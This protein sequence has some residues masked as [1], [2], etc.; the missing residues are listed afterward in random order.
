M[1]NNNLRE[2]IFLAALLHD[3]GKFYQ[4]S[5]DGFSDKYNSLSGYS[6]RMAEDICPLND[7]GR[8]GYQHVVWT[9]EFFEITKTILKRIPEISENVFEVSNED[10]IANLACNHHRPKSI[11]QSII[12]MADWWSAG[13]DRRSESTLE[14]DETDTKDSKISWGKTRYKDIPLYSIFNSIKIRGMQN[15]KK[16]AFPLKPIDISKECFP[17]EINVK[18]DGVSQKKYKILWDNF[19]SEFKNL[20]S[21]SINGFTESLIYLLK[22]HTWCIPSNTMDMANVSLFDHLKTTAAFADCIYTYYKENN[23]D[24]NWNNSDNRLTLNDK[25]YPVILLGGDISGIQKFIYNI[26]SRK[27][28]TSLKGRSFYLQLLIDSI[29]QRIISHEKIKASIGHVVYSSGGKFYMLLPNT[30][31]VKNAVAEINNEIEKELW[32]E[33]KGKLVFNLDYIPFAYRTKEREIDFEGVPEKKKDLGALW[34][35]L[36]N[37]LTEKKNQKFKSLL[38]NDYN[39]FFDVQNTGGKV[40]I[41]CITGEES[42]N[43]EIHDKSDKNNVKYISKSAKEQEKLGNT[44]KDVDYLITFKG[45]EQNSN[46]LSNQLKHNTSLFGVANYLFDQIELTKNDADFRKITS[47]DVSRVK[48]INDTSF[49]AAPFKGKQVS[50]GFQFYGGNKQAQNT[51]GSNKTFED[52]TKHTNDETYLGILRMDVDGLGE[53][54]IN[55]I[56]ETDKSFSAYATLSSNLDWFFSGYLNTIREKYSDNINILY[57]GGDDV[58]A[59]GR[60]DSLISFAEDIR[61]EFKRF[62]GRDDLSISAGITIVNNKFPIAKA[63]ELAGQAEHLAKM[64]ESAELGNKNAISFLGNTI[65]WNKEFAV[66]KSKKDEFVNLIKNSGMSKGILHRIMIFAEI[67][68]D[69]KKN[70]GKTD[71]VPDLSYHW[72]AAYYLKRFMENKDD[73]VKDFCKTLQPDMYN[74]KTLELIALAARWAELQLKLDDKKNVEN[75]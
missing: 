35:A 31:D 53:I 28:A 39:R 38:L 58:F 60:W 50:Y 4:R 72:N 54:F 46:Y 10:N 51:D 21:D 57:S 49:L 61:S 52:L 7:K 11:L 63:A 40:N 27:A 17:K 68:A 3:I 36:A 30:A 26:A 45:D 18:E 14:K 13:I 70:K 42:P 62:V 66:V 44:L 73:V 25:K 41:C 47:A 23:T 43:L 22:K 56:A 19:M 32:K 24:F 6:K 34:K 16:L 65:S 37:K 64:F 33:H 71:F 5:D 29:V 8:F 2:K 74:D 1:E 59:V 9:N 12:T 67:Q 75:E 55:G 15:D 69:N 48:R 20:P